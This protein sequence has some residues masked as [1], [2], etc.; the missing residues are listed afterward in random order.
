MRT[1]LYAG[2]LDSSEFRRHEGMCALCLDDHTSILD[3]EEPSSLG[4]SSSM[5]LAWAFQ[6]PCPLFS[7]SA[8]APLDLPRQPEGRFW[9]VGGRC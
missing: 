7:L 2:E 5:G 1:A 4:G 8:P 6:G 9:E 3:P